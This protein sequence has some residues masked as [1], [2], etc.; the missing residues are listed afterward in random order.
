M[1]KKIEY[2]LNK[3]FKKNTNKCCQQITTHLNKRNLET[4]YL[5]TINTHSFLVTLSPSL[6]KEKIRLIEI[7]GIIV[8]VIGV[9]LILIA[10]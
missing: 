1:K 2:F 9:I 4:K 7:I 6:I 3:T 8:F 10:K 5:S